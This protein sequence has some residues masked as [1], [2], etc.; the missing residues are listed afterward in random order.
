MIKNIVKH[1]TEQ[2]L[3]VVYELTYPVNTN[4]VGLITHRIGRT[5]KLFIQPGIIVNSN[6]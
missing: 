3:N 1:C 2:G 6:V 4:T 5:A